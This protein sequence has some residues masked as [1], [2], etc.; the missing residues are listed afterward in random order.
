MSKCNKPKDNI[1]ELNQ[2]IT[3]NTCAWMCYARL[4]NRYKGYWLNQKNQIV[5]RHKNKKYEIFINDLENEK[6]DS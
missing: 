3:K 2:E 1:E 5:E 6:F 4:D